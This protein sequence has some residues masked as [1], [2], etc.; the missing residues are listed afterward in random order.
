MGI[1][2]YS[3]RCVSVQLRIV[4]CIV[5]HVK[6]FDALIGAEPMKAAA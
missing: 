3:I 4:E 6:P 2:R 1:Y 5:G